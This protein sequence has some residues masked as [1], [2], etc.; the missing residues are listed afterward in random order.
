MSTSNFIPGTLWTISALFNAFI[1]AFHVWSIARTAFFALHIILVWSF[2]VKHHFKELNSLF[3]LAVMG[4][5]AD[6]EEDGNLSF[7]SSG[8]Y[9]QIFHVLSR[10]YRENHWLLSILQRFNKQ[11]V[12]QLFFT[13]LVSNIFV[14]LVV[15]ANLLFGNLSPVVITMMMLIILAQTALAYMAAY[16]LA[17][18]SNCFYQS[19]NLLYRLQLK[20]TGNWQKTEKLH[21]KQLK[22]IYL[23]N[24][25]II[26]KLK[27]AVFYEKVCTKNKFCFT[28]GAHSKISHKTMYEFLFVYS[29]FIMYVSKMFKNERL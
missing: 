9:A 3:T 8:F 4:D 13:G 29:G 7:G 10:F 6:T 14:N 27:L 19:N 15:I 16:G 25:W 11:V 28:F 24:A 20:I 21:F 26:Q 23:K 18:I 12:S 1:I 5:A 2:A 17:G 22:L